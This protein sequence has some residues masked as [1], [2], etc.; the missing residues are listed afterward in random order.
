MPTFPN[1]MTHGVDHPGSNLRVDPA[2]LILLPITAIVP[3]RWQPRQ[4][5]AAERL[6]ELA[7]DIRQHGVLTPPIVWQNED[8][9]YEL[10]AGER[11]LRA[12]HALALSMLSILS[13]LDTAIAHVAE[14]GITGHYASILKLRIAMGELP[15]T[16]S[17]VPCR[18]VA[19]APADLH[20]LA[21]VDNLQ[22][23]D[24]SPLEE[25]HALHD[26]VQEY[27]YTQRQLAERLGKSQTWISQRLILLDLAPAVADQVASGEVDAATAREIARLAPAVQAPAVAHLQKHNMKSRAAQAFVGK[28]LDLSDPQHYAAPAST[29]A[30]R[31]VGMALT[32]LPDPA[33]RQA[34]VVAAATTIS[35][36]KLTNDLD[37]RELLVASGIAGVGKTRYDIDVTALWQQYALAAGYGCAFCQI[38]PQRTIVE[39]INALA[40]AHK[41]SNLND[42]AWPRCA[43]GV[44]TCRAYCA[45]GTAPSLTLPSF[46]GSFTLTPE[47]QAHVTDAWPRRADD[48]QI[49]AGLTQRYN[50]EADV[51]AV[52]MQDDQES[53]LRRALAKYLTL[54]RS[55]ELASAPNAQHQPCNTCVFHK[56]DADDPDAHCQFQ[57]YPPDW[58]DHDKAV[59]RLWSSGNSTIGRC[60]LY[61]LKQPEVNLPELPGG[62]DVEPAGL[63]YLLARVS[64]RENY[65]RALW[66]PRWFDSKRAKTWE[67]PSWSIVEPVLAKLIPQLGPGQRLAL[68]LLWEDPF[69]WQIGYGNDHVTVEAFVPQLGR[70]APYTLHETI[71]R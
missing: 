54:Q 8:H 60:R 1:T 22:R 19:G 43:P 41:E 13:P 31:L 15:T 16:T 53:G 33:A 69:H 5:F 42:E 68:L 56:T 3:S 44:A 70:V 58:H 59:I 12:C 11:R 7:L 4:I 32:E 65:G 66:G 45:P 17:S 71:E 39:E 6:L 23:E 64:Q 52:R 46:G 67:P 55:G 26:L 63:R 28:V 27:G 62:I 40:C 14:H 2:G 21:L 49:W 36:G 47:E 35:D 34:A 30:T 20:E 9:E 25:A 10:I 61:R 24:L 50:A 48:V 37:R 38:N 18:L 51:K 29:P 57:A